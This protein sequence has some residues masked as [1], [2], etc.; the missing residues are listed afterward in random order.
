[1]VYHSKALYNWD[2]FL[3]TV[4]LMPLHEAY[5]APDRLTP[6]LKTLVHLQ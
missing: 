6:T 1:M 4:Q 3:D 2:I 5:I